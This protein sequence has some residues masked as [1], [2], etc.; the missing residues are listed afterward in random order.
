MATI[1]FRF[2]SL[3]VPDIGSIDRELFQIK[4]R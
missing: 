1:G 2:M 4:I 3:L